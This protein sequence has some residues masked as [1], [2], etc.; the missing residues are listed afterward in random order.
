MMTCRW[1]FSIDSR[2][3]TVSV[4]NH[5]AVIHPR[6]NSVKHITG[7]VTQRRC[8]LYQW[9]SWCQSMTLTE[10]RRLA[11]ASTMSPLV[12]LWG[13]L[14]VIN[15]IKLSTDCTHFVITCLNMLDIKILY[16]DKRDVP[17]IVAAK[18]LFPV[19]TSGAVSLSRRCSF[20]FRDQRLERLLPDLSAMN[21]GY[22]VTHISLHTGAP[23]A[24]SG[25]IEEKS[26]QQ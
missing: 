7:N 11:A 26:K 25:E 13:R 20:T 21:A 9:I 16:V 24:R 8:W 10:S 15:K 1:L 23:R 18:L 4:C 14:T 5:L 19:E 3:L 12:E 17:C 2:P 22:W 6:D